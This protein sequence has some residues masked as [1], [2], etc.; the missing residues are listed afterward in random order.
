MP[1]EIRR[2]P[3]V[4]YRQYNPAPEFVHRLN[5]NHCTQAEIDEYKP[6]FLKKICFALEIDFWP[7]ASADGS[8]IEWVGDL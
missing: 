7:L 2:H 8:M 6:E 1:F 3:L 5:S 4:R